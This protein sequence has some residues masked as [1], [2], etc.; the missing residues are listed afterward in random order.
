MRGNPKMEFRVT[1]TAIDR[2]GV[3][4]YT[5]NVQVGVPQTYMVV[6]QLFRNEAISI[7]Q[8]YEL[9]RSPEPHPN[10]R[11]RAQS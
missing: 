7:G 3:D 10:T 4:V 5:D 6:Q 1:L 11:G 9:V 8:C 2:R